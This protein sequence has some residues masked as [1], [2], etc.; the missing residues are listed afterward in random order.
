M[1]VFAFFLISICA[2]VSFACIDISGTYSINGIVAVKYEQNQ[3]LK[4]TESWC[5]KDGSDCADS[6]SW[7]MDGVLRQDGGNPANWAAIKSV[8]NLSIY[9]E[10]YFENGTTHNGNQCYWRSQ[11]FSLD[12][13]KNLNV[14]YKLA[15][16]GQDGKTEIVFVSDTWNR[17]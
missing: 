17:L 9:R 14:K 7:D 13:D 8:D 15:C 1:K 6:F 4:L 11:W 12:S 5:R 2:C 3:C 16:I 10:Q